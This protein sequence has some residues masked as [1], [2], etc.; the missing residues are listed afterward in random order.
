MA[1]VAKGDVKAGL[2][3]VVGQVEVD[4]GGLRGEAGP[5]EPRLVIPII[6]GMNPRPAGEGIALLRLTGTLHI[7]DSNNSSSQVGLPAT[8]DLLRGFYVRSLP[9]GPSSHGVDLRFQL[10]VY[11]VHRL[12]VARQAVTEGDFTLTLRLDGPLAWIRNTRGEALVTPGQPPTVDSTDPFQMQLGLHSDLSV[13]WTSE[14]DQLRLQIDQSVW[15]NNVLPG[16]GIDN[17]RLVEIFLPPGLPDIGNASTVFDDARRAYDQRRYA[18]CIAKCRGIIQ[19]WNKQ[20]AASKKQHLAELVAKSQN[21]PQDDP[22]RK[23]LDSVWQ[24]LLES[25]NAANHPEGQDALYRPTVHD[26]RLQLMMTAV[27]SEYLHQVLQ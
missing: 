16:F 13:F 26:A 22:R 3:R 20:L 17:I 21:W 10:S 1:R 23:L 19:A 12:E 18:D 11:A 5:L 8:V 9:G 7:G 25:A 14:I 24:A 15:I 6:V 4:P 2:S 27:I